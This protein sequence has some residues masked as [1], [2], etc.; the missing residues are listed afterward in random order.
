[1]SGGELLDH[2]DALAR[3]Q[4]ESEV[5][6]LLAARQHAVLNDTDSIDPLHLTRRPAASVPRRL[7]GAG[8]PLVAEFAP[9]AFAARLGSRRTPGGS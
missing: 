8:T 1:M 3:L 2:V 9:A 4:R 7:G 6:V 5:K